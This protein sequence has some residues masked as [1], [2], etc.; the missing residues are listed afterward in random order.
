MVA[1]TE[2]V[3]YGDEDG[4]E[5]VAASVREVCVVD[6]SSSSVSPRA[7]LS[8][9]RMITATARRRRIMTRLREVLIAQDE[10]VTAA[11]EVHETHLSS[12]DRGIG[13]PDSACRCSVAGDA[14]YRD[15]KEDLVKAGLGCLVEEHDEKARYQ[16][17]NDGIKW[18]YMRAVVPG[19]VAGRAVLVPF[20]VV[21]S[22]S[23]ALL[24]GKD[25]LRKWSCGYQ[26][27]GA[28]LSSISGGTETTQQLGVSRAQHDANPVRPQSGLAL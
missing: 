7:S 5:S 21:H 2:S 20:S 17:G 24:L 3:A 9:L 1:D 15:Y 14:W 27:D 6:D 4:G 28:V 25:V 11:N 19:V 18:S 12:Q 16:F 8:S 26:F 22:D 10:P 23:L 13:I